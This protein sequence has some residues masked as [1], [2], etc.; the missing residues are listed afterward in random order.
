MMKKILF[1][2]IIA[3]CPF[4]CHAQIGSWTTQNIEDTYG[5]G[6]VISQ[7]SKEIQKTAAEQ[8]LIEKKP[9]KYKSFKFEIDYSGNIQSK[10]IKP[11]LD[12]KYH[13]IDECIFDNTTYVRLQAVNS[14]LVF[15]LPKDFFEKHILP[16]SYL[17]NKVLE[18][19]NNT[20]VNYQYIEK[21]AYKN[22]F[23]ITDYNDKKRSISLYSIFLQYGVKTY[24]KISIK[25]VILDKTPAVTLT[26]A[27]VYFQNPTYSLSEIESL[28]KGHAL[29]TNEEM[30]LVLEEETKVLD[31][32]KA[33]FNPKDNIKD[34][35]SRYHD[36][37]RNKL[38][39][40]MGQEIMCCGYYSSYTIG[41]TYV[42][43]YTKGDIYII[44]SVLPYEHSYD[45]IRLCVRNKKGGVMTLL[46]GKVSELND[47][48]IVMKHLE[49]LRDSLT[50]REYIYQH[51]K[52][53]YGSPIRQ[54]GSNKQMADVPTKTIWKCIDV[55]SQV[56]VG[57]NVFY[58]ANPI[59]VFQNEEYGQG[60]CYLTST[61]NKEKPVFGY[62]MTDKQ[63]H[64]AKIKAEQ[65]AKQER[66]NK[67]SAKYGKYYAKL[68]AEGK[69][70]RG[71]TKEM[72][73]ESWGEPDDINVSIGSWG[74][75]E[76]WVY[77]EI[78]SSYLYFE[79]GKLTTIQN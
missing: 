13:V 53:S 39:H 1:V 48:W 58:S 56:Q 49:Y 36:I 63:E 18:F 71:M 75:H 5:Q 62:L 9:G 35:Y 38:V 37:F 52:D 14:E 74:R 33:L 69:V 79:N 78:Y 59:I 44:D 30:E 2:A 16:N 12:G 8:T 60:Y 10:L 19:V 46:S 42:G 65:K 76:Q 24:A 23:G 45:P 11:Y 31:S 25:D 51:E 17:L 47:N 41:G 29:L 55:Q 3:I 73:K 26:G 68:I 40:L 70:V 6:I 4:L 20:L 22:V 50:G 43:T 32:A 57:S 54:I 15:L 61:G 34:G 21:E 64:E 77:G 7:P 72:C 27:G 66:I 28:I 67:L